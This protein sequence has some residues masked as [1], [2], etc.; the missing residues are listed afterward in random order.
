M[1]NSNSKAAE[2][3]EQAEQA[4]RKL[5]LNMR[6]E[7]KAPHTQALAN[8]KAAVRA[9]NKAQVNAVN[10]VK[11]AI[12]NPTAQSVNRAAGALGEA[13]N[14][15]NRL[16]RAQ[17]VLAQAA[18]AEAKEVPIGKNNSN[19]TRNNTGKKQGFLGRVGGAVRRVGGAV[20]GGAR[21]TRGAVV[22]GAR[23]TG[24][25]LGGLFRPRSRPVK[26]NSETAR[27]ID[28]PPPPNKR[29]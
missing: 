26:P 13:L 21:A 20:A 29:N 15:S 1:A 19:V 12:V 22:G 9:Y 27:L 14:T 8:F 17:S 23:V 24:G 28:E 25:A 5:L 11:K 16:K 18:A 4:L 6:N 10:A 7:T 3:A 2:Q